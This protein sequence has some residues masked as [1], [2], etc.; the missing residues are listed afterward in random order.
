MTMQPF[1]AQYLEEELERR[2]E[3]NARYSLRGFASYL[4]MD[5]SAL[6]RILAG[7]QEMSIQMALAVMQ[8]LDLSPEDQDRFVV[9][10]AEEK[11][12]RTLELL[13]DGARVQRLVQELHEREMALA[14]QSRFIQ[15]ALSSVPD[16]VY[17]FTRDH[18]IVYA[19]RAMQ[20]LFGLSEVQMVGKTLPDLGYPPELVT[21][22]QAEIDR[23]FEHGEQIE[24]EVRFPDVKRGM[25]RLHYVWGPVFGADGKVELGIGVTRDTTLRSDELN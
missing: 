24:G 12:R 3:K 8:K 14:R 2:K 20:D 6:S 15:A 10:V 17:A 21:R 23:L 1:Y 9:S 18:R 16:C 7:K 4:D 13:G 25:R 5:P 11:Y 22:F 19:N